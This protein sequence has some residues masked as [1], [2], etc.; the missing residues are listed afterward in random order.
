MPEP[1]V[2]GK[3]KNPKRVA[4]G[5]ANRALRGPVGLLTR[6]RLSRAAI[7]TQPWLHSTG[8]RTQAGKKKS[9]QN[10]CRRGGRASVQMPM[11]IFTQRALFLQSMIHS[12]KQRQSGAGQPVTSDWNRMLVEQLSGQARELTV[13]PSNP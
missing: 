13:A 8:P 1:V 3:T 9:A 6:E 2:S 5:R 7:R 4:A 10:G 11:S 12:V